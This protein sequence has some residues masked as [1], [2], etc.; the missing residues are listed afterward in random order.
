MYSE[1]EVVLITHVVWLV[2]C[3]DSFD[4]VSPECPVTGVVRGHVGSVHEMGHPDEKTN[5]GEEPEGGNG[6]E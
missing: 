2:H 6:G 1:N 3:P 5:V 4:G